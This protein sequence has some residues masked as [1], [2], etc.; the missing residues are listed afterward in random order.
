MA[1]KSNLEYGVVEYSEVDK[2][3]KK[4]ISPGAHH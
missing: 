1:E 2:Q 4:Q 3:T